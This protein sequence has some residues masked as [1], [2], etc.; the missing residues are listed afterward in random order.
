MPSNSLDAAYKSTFVR[1]SFAPIVRTNG[2]NIYGT[3]VDTAEKGGCDS[4]VAFVMPGTI[5]DGTHTLTIQESDDGSTGWS[6]I[7]G[8][9]VYGTP[10]P[11]LTSASGTTPYEWGITPAKRYLS[12]VLTVT[13]ATT[14]GAYA[15][16]FIMVDSHYEAH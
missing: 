13:G 1:K 12:F 9:R 6:A 8:G 3:A 7:P 5:T 2:S 10:A 15:C 16:G 4:V 11:G 14:G